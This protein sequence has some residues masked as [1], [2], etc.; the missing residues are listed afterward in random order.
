MMN[1]IG[2]PLEDIDTP[3][4]LV[5][6]DALERN[7]AHMARVI[8]QEAGINWRPHSKGIKSPAIAHLLVDAG[9][10]GVTCAKL[11]EAEVMAAGGIRNILIANQIVG[12]QKVE[13]LVNL[14]KHA[15][16][17]PA[18]D[19]EENVREIAEAAERKGVRQRLVVEVNV[20]IDRAGVLPGE[21]VVA[22]AKKIAAYPSL[23]FAGVMGWE[24]Q[25]L[26]AKDDTEKE[27][28]VKEVIARLTGS[29]QQCRDAGLP[30]EIVS[31][32]G[33]GTYWHTAFQPGVTEI[34][35][36]GGIFCDIT[37]RERFEV[38]HEFALTVLSTVTSRPA[39]TRIICDA[40]KKT[41]STDASTPKPRG[42]PERN[43][44]W[45]LSRAWH[46]PVGRAVRHSP[47][48][49][50]TAVHRG[51]RGHDSVPARQLL[52]HSR[53]SRG[54]GVAYSGARETAVEMTESSLAQFVRQESF[55]LR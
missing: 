18:V 53:W 38:P 12:P 37:Y 5:E 49:G 1:I 19:S 14:R 55:S 30:V 43:L 42:L 24:A 17:I 25:V 39:P 7:V 35:A 2:R 28:M 48:W 44:R 34:Q 50:Q 21:P 15:D 26:G 11:G 40:G 27:Q 45:M 29:A 52:R 3:A 10:I 6:L 13:R 22:L 51:L 36:G 23:E 33:S 54:S 46:D 32:G 8:I 47:R 31:C 9:A 20:G 41:M 16:V 4:L